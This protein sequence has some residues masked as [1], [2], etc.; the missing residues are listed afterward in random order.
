MGVNVG[1]RVLRLSVLSQHTR[2]DLVHLADKLEHRVIG[3]VLE[4]KFALGHVAR[5]RLAEHS[6]TVSRND[7]TSLK[8]RPEVVLDVLVAE[9]GA[10]AGLHLLEP[11]E[12]FLV[13]EAVEGTG[14]TVKT[15]GER[16]HGGGEGGTDQV[17]GVGGD[18]TTL[19]VGVDGQVQTHELDKVGVVGETE[20][21]G[22]VVGVVLVLLN[23]GD[24]AVF[25]D[26]AVDA[27]GDGGE[28]SNEVHGV[29][30]VVL[31]VLGLLDTA[32]VGLGEGGFT[33]ESGDGE[34]ELGHGVEVAGASVD[35]LLNVLR[36][37]GASSPLGGKVADLLLG[38]DLTG[39]KE[40]EKTLGKGLLTTR[41]LGEEFLAFGDLND[42]M[43]RGTNFEQIVKTDSLA[44]E[45]NTLLGV[46][47]GTFPDEGLDTTSTTVDLVE[48]DLANDFAAVL[49]G[50]C[51][52]VFPSSGL[53][54]NVLLELL[55][56]L[57]LTGNLLA[58]GV[59]ERLH[60]MVS[61]IDQLS[62]ER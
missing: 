37:L 4:R 43:S 30:E 2:R 14:K 51:E 48:S 33:L 57:N 12:D 24:L 23:G 55:D 29:L 11:L 54:P 35:E 21:L 36:N 7:T 46:E 13:G 3:E 50:M 34:G 22:E 15:S 20:L 28:F 9:V 16:E 40:P 32:G 10:D 18:V 44:T 49:P 17:G 52:D 59:L 27:G 19:V 53:L 1:V 42:E 62:F 25:V 41:R 5:I 8:G 47:N 61:I 26:V 39:E 56:L 60:D 31:P 45:A 58:E 6:V 38:W